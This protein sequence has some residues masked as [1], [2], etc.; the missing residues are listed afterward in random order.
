MENK[1]GL[2][3]YFSD[4]HATSA[5]LNLEWHAGAGVAQ[6]RIKKDFK[7][8]NDVSIVSGKDLLSG[9]ELLVA[10]TTHRVQFKLNDAKTILPLTL[11][12]E[13]E[14]GGL[15]GSSTSYLPSRIEAFLQSRPYRF[16]TGQCDKTATLDVDTRHHTGNSATGRY[17]SDSANGWRFTKSATQVTSIVAIP[18]QIPGTFANHQELWS[19]DFQLTVVLGCSN[20]SGTDIQC[21]AS[22]SLQEERWQWRPQSEFTLITK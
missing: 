7:L 13:K 10:G 18:G 22:T 19:G 11:N 20:S 9:K 16:D 6:V 2:L 4:V 3:T 12:V 5:V 15:A 17:C 1:I 21:H 8:P 14:R